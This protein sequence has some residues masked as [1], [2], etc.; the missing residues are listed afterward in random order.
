MDEGETDLEQLENMLDQGLLDGRN[1]ITLD[2]SSSEDDDDEC[3]RRLITSISV[4]EDES[5]LL[6]M[7]SGTNQIHS[8]ELTTITT[9]NNTTS[10]E[11]TV[12]NQQLVEHKRT[13]M[14]DSVI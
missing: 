10:C 7:V 6:V 8:F 5:T 14:V 9:T 12:L 3:K 1:V 13:P 4:S 11:E 2:L